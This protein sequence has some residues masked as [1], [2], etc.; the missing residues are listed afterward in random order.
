[1]AEGVQAAIETLSREGFAAINDFLDP[2]RALLIREEVITARS[3]G[4][5]SQGNIG[6]GNVNTAVRG[7][8]LGWFD[9]DEEGWANLEHYLSTADAV[10]ANCNSSI[11]E[12][13][14]IGGVT[15]RT[16]GMVTCYPGGGA[17]YIKHIDNPDKNG[18]KLTFMLYLND[19]WEPSHGGQLRVYREDGSHKDMS[20]PPALTLT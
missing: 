8:Q 5:L 1:M 18:R 13:S 4:K 15:M 9:G 6:G 11:P 17:K 14:N 3:K 16:P 10:V 7:D 19:S 12:L 2:E 20:P